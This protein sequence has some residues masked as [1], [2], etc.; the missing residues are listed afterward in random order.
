M[1][2]PS[3][4]ALSD[5]AAL[6]LQQGDL[7]LLVIN[8]GPDGRWAPLFA[9]PGFLKQTGLTPEAV[10]GGALADFLLPQEANILQ[11]AFDR[12]LSLNQPL[13]IEE[14]LTCPR[15]RM[16][17]Q[18]RL[19]PQ[20][21]A[22]NGN[23]LIL[24]LGRDVSDQR[25]LEQ[26]LKEAERKNRALI[27]A[28]PDVIIRLNKDGVILDLEEGRDTILGFPPAELLGRRLGDMLPGDATDAASRQVTR[29]FHTKRTQV[30]EHQWHAEGLTHDFEVRIVAAG[31]DEALAILRDITDRKRAERDLRIAKEQAEI[32]NR[33]KSIFLATVSHELRTPLNA[34]I[35]FSDVIRHEMFGPL[36]SPRYLDYA[37]DIHDSGA[38]L[39]EIINDILD[40]S[41]LEAGRIDLHE[42]NFNPNEVIRLIMHLMAGRINDANLASELSLLPDVPMLYADKRV[43]KQ[44]LLNLLS[45]A[46][47]FTPEGGRVGITTQTDIAGALL[48]A[49]WDTGI[50]IAPE[51]VAIAMTPFAQI[52]SS[53]ARKHPGTG[54]G[55]PLVK[56]LIELHGGNL[57]LESSLGQ[58]TKMILRFPPQRSVGKSVIQK[59]EENDKPLPLPNKKVMVFKA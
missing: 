58:G 18:F 11:A 23:A 25:R 9:S 43:F 59:T 15:G 51:D 1:L 7:G 47:K 36:G 34:V 8:L 48:V 57:R 31:E 30:F 20:K 54:L 21:N 52:D 44:M 56:S 50:G 46:V 10:S 24:A 35:G 28:M 2:K 12:C 40:L 4:P 6:L 55:L 3:H 53:L 33:T 39:L 14:V 49:V 29:A 16:V 19:L 17:W 37:Q 27:A 41:K 38:H 42:E 5:W 22:S 45:N 13:Q 32:A 26:A